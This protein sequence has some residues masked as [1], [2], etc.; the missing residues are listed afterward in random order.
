MVKQ[1]LMTFCDEKQE[2]QTEHLSPE[3]WDTLIKIKAFLQPFYDTTKA[4]EDVFHAIDRILPGMEYLLE[5]LETS[6]RNYCQ[7]GYLSTHV[8]AAWAKLDEYYNK[9]N[10][11]IA[12]FTATALNLLYKWKW[13]KWR[14]TTTTLKI[15]CRN[16]KKR[17]KD[18]WLKKYKTIGL[19]G[20]G[21][22]NNKMVTSNKP[23]HQENSF[24]TWIQEDLTTNPKVDKFETYFSEQSI[25]NVPM[26][27]FNALA[28]WSE[29]SQ[30][31]HF[32]RL[33][34]M[35]F[36]LLTIPTMSSSIERVF[37]ECKL[38]CLRHATL[39]ETLKNLH[40]LRSWLKS[41]MLEGIQLISHLHFKSIMLTMSSQ[42]KCP[43]SFS[44]FRKPSKYPKTKLLIETMEAGQSL[45]MALATLNEVIYRIQAL[46]KIIAILAANLEVG[47]LWKRQGTWNVLITIYTN[48]TISD[49]TISGR[50][51]LQTH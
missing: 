37:S 19:G 29:D 24:Y 13:I 8:D 51:S 38:T 30:R 2:L 16:A 23:E 20:Q 3:N 10:I 44:A 48:I 49:R 22:N 9:S 31:K 40:L 5:H 28:W 6:R 39:P 36:D 1:T 47:A 26:K 34:R 11:T 7:H 15:T 45:I 41:T 27:K 32:P 50:L 21:L 33:S 43:T 14:W 18:L 42:I 35:V 17:M 12:Y 4:T 25:R 46:K